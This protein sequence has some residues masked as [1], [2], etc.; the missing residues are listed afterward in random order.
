M[1]ARFFVVAAHFYDRLGA[2]DPRAILGALARVNAV[3]CQLEFAA[4]ASLS[5]IAKIKIGEECEVLLHR[6][7]AIVQR[8]RESAA[9]T[10]ALLDTSREKLLSA[11][12]ILQL[13]AKMMQQSAESSLQQFIKVRKRT[14]WHC[15]K[16]DVN[17]RV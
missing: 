11:L 6:A 17:C 15:N 8:S 16:H 1:S 3:V 14:R 13:K 2:D 10:M 4:G 9:A 5:N 7:G 12:P